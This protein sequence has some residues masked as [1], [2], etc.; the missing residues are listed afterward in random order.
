[1]LSLYNKLFT[2]FNSADNV[3]AVS[4]TYVDWS[5]KFTKKNCAHFIPIGAPTEK[6]EKKFCAVDSNER[7]KFFYVGSLSFIYDIDTLVKSF[8]S[9]E[10]KIPVEFHVFGGNESEIAKFQNSSSSKYIYFHGVQDYKHLVDQVSN[11]HVAINPIKANASQSLTN[12]L[13]DYL[14]WGHPILN[15][16][17]NSEVVSLLDNRKYTIHYAAENI[18]SCSSAIEKMYLQHKNGTYQVPALD[19]V[20]SE[21]FNRLVKLIEEEHLTN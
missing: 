5:R 8:E 13:C 18:Q 11:M 2:I 21:V 16:Q 10:D 7:M 20:R 9:I 17:D 12:K 4:Q 14:A 6:K 19:F 15:C 3:I 1:M